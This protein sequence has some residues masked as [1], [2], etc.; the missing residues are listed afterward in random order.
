M[1][2]TMWNSK[3]YKQT[4]HCR[5]WQESDFVRRLTEGY[6]RAMQ[7]YAHLIVKIPSAL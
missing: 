5:Y 3:V 7:A 2:K 1:P 6:S 4:E